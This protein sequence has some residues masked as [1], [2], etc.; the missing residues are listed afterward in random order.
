[1]VWRFLCDNLNVDA[2]Y[3]R[4]GLTILHGLGPTKLKGNGGG[5]EA[6][7]SSFGERISVYL[8]K[9]EEAEKRKGFSVSSKAYLDSKENGLFIEVYLSQ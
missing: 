8:G 5:G 4:I 6:V 2:Q 7:C 3:V 1:M 9:M